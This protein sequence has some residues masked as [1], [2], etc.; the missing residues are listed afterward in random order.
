[1][2]AR[3]WAPPSLPHPLFTPLHPPFTPQAVYAHYAAGT[4]GHKD[5]R[6]AWVAGRKH[7]GALGPALEPVA[8]GSAA[9]TAPGDDA[10]ERAKLLS[11]AE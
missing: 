4:L 8:P 5:E 9:G 10:L 6:A 7:W 3:N 2:E 11:D 1:M